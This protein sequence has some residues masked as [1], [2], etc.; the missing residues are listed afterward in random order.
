MAIENLSNQN[1][2]DV[3][4]EIKAESLKEEGTF[5]GYGSTF[6]K[7]PDSY[8][9]V[10]APGAFTKTIKKKGRN[11]NGIAMLWQHESHNP[12]GIWPDME[13]DKKGL[14]VFGELIL[15]VQQAKE[16]HALMKKKA[17]RG[18][19][20]GW[21]FPRTKG[22]RIVDG[23]YEWNEDKRIRTLK[24]IELWEIS[25]VTFPAKKPA[26]IIGV[27]AIEEA[28]TERDLEDIL[29]ESGLS[30]AAALYIVKLCRPSLRESGSV[31]DVGKLSGLN[32][33]SILTSLKKV[34]AGLE[35]SRRIY[36]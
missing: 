23:V 4:F 16:A 17:L 12:I 13:E 35:V 24:E 26:R 28:V 31:D 32:L 27:K 2:L 36:G 10:I 29:R 5:E 7:S 20:I 30:K 25:P 33:D 18:L 3:P 1:Y 15:E 6:D 11:G 21:D 8:G 22:G 34:N 9:D 14:H 19:S